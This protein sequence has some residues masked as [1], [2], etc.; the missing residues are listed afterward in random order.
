MSNIVEGKPF[1]DV[2]GEL[3]GGDLLHE[4]TAKLYE[5]GRAVRET[6]KEG[7][8]KLSIKLSPTGKSFI[9]DAKIEAKVPEHDR[10]STTFFMT[11]EGTL[12]RNDPN[13]P[14]LPLREVMDE[15]TGELRTV[16]G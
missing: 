3:E 13:Q 11:D 1:T 15:Q 16:R 10:P 4:L 6:R 5:V 8:I 12:M 9:L 2:I 14:R 7:S